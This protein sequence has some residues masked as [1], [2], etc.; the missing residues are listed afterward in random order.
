[1]ALRSL[2]IL[3]FTTFPA[4]AQDA[5]KSAAP[6]D[7]ELQSAVELCFTITEEEK[8]AAKIAEVVASCA[9]DPETLLQAIM[10]PP[11]PRQAGEK[12]QLSVPFDGNA[13]PVKVA[14]PMKAGEAPPPVVY[15]VS[16]NSTTHFPFESPALCQVEGY[17]PEQF[18]DASRDSW[19]K[20]LHS[21]SYAVG[22]D[23]DRF[24]FI[25]FS[26]GGHA[27]FD[28]AA[29]RPGLL[30]GFVSLA[31]GPRRNHFRLLPNLAP[32][33][34]LSYAGAKDDAEMVWNLNELARLAPSLKLDFKFTLDPV[35][36]HTLP[37]KG[38]DEVVSLIDST[39]STPPSLAKSGVVF[40]DADHVALPWL[41]VVETDHALVEVPDVFPVGGNLSADEKRRAMV[42]AM[43]D[44]VARVSWKAEP[45][46]GGGVSLTLTTKGVKRAAIFVK[47]PWFDPSQELTVT[48]NG[49][50]VFKGP[51][52]IDAATLLR[53]ARRTGDRQ[54]PTLQRI[55]VDLSR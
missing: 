25:G 13:Y 4:A 33:K 8:A 41:E 18:S 26:W 50:K 19:R 39:P 43:A 16:W 22:G 7:R 3:A 54:R 55:D 48:A 10:A 31:G 53:E 23:P 51:I 20:F 35:Q 15:D 2:P 6:R 24:W 29:H 40:A 14:A 38:M 9:S 32:T 37:L 11:P 30:R 21:V 44:H 52:K 28:V 36:G 12:F 34:I 46:K 45:V 5:P 27:G 42:H 47:A 49:K 17:T 1:V